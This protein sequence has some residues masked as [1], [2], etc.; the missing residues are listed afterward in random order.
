[1][2]F[3]RIK[4]GIIGPV[5]KIAN[6]IAVCGDYAQPASVLQVVTHA[7]EDRFLKCDVFKGFSLVC[8]GKSADHDFGYSCKQL[9]LIFSL[10]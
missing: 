4:R 3:A 5:A 6:L 10:T 2:Y 9:K 8:Y 1:M 7:T